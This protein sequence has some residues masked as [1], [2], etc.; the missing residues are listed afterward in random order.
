MEGTRRKNDDRKNLPS[1]HIMKNC[2]CQ[3][4]WKKKCNEK[5][6]GPIEEKTWHARH[7]IL[8]W[9]I[10]NIKILKIQKASKKSTKID[11][12]FILN[13]KK[14]ANSTWLYW[15]EKLVPDTIMVTIKLLSWIAFVR[16]ILYTE[17]HW[18]QVVYPIY[19]VKVLLFQIYS[20]PCAECS[21]NSL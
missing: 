13:T 3:W 9:F 5:E 14:N 1:I 7:I 21:F 18:L 2:I 12:Q 15:T 4:Q 10:Q 11:F 6:S 20:I 17:I 8:F 16:I 19:I